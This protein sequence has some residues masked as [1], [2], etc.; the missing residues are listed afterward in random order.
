MAHRPRPKGHGECASR[1][2]AHVFGH[3]YAARLCEVSVFKPSMV[4]E[5]RCTRAT[6]KIGLGSMGLMNRADFFSIARRTA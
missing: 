5:M 4:I 1:Q 2:A 3:R 6:D